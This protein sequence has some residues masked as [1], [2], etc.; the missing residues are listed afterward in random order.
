M[1]G[2]V[3]DATR[4]QRRRL[5]PQGLRPRSRLAETGPPG[6]EGTLAEGV[7]SA[8]RLVNSIRPGKASST[9]TALPVARR[10]VR[11]SFSGCRGRSAYPVQ[12]RRRSAEAGD[13]GDQQ[14]DEFDPE[15]QG[16]EAAE[17][18]AGEVAAQQVVGGGGV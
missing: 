1:V 4:L 15:E 9:S 16:E 17:S 2:S 7:T 5:C 11:I 10:A 3:K 12:L 14:V 18:I 13:R 6:A 8:L